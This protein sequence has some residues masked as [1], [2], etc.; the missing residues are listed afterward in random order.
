MSTRPF[1]TQK[2]LELSSAA[3]VSVNLFDYL[4]DDGISEDPT[5]ISSKPSVV[6]V[7]PAT[8]VITVK[9]TGS[10]RIYAVYGADTLSDKM[11]SRKKY[12]IKI[13]VK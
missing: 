4:S 3:S 9:G 12:N 7:D 2:K 5:W 13:K 8:G 10:A 1:N 6:S 11:G